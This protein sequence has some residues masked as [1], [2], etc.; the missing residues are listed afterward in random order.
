M[1]DK[2]KQMNL[3]IMW[4]QMNNVTIM[5]DEEGEQTQITFQHRI[6]LYIL[7]LET[8]RTVNIEL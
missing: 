8:E 2:Q 6:W 1:K 7:G 3:S 4:F 5:K